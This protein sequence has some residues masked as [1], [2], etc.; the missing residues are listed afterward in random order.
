MR[1]V[2]SA[3]VV[4]LDSTAQ[5]ENARIG[6][7]SHSSLPPHELH[8]RKYRISMLIKNLSI[9]EGLCNGTRLLILKL[10]NTVLRCEIWSGDEK[11]NIVFLHRITLY[12]END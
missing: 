4:Y 8:F 6:K 7:P 11:G 12:C 5:P 9:N 10:G 2:A 1:S 3:L